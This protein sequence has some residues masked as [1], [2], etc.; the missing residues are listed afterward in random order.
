MGG[1]DYEEVR[2]QLRARGYL[3]GRLE[4]FVLHDPGRPLR[5]SAKAALLGAPVL[6]ALLAL[7]AVAA[8]RPLL[9]VRDALVLWLYFSVLAG[10][11]LWALDLAAAAAVSALARRRG[12]K[13]SDAL[14]AALLVGFPTLLY[15]VALWTTQRGGS[16]LGA[17]LAFLAAAAVVTFFTAWLAGLVSL[18]AIV[19]R[20]GEVPDRRRRPIALAALLAGTAALAMLVLR[21]GETDPSQG[22]PA[23]PLHPVPAGRLVVLGIDGLDADLARALSARD[24]LPALTAAEARGARWPLRRRPGAE[25]PEAWTTLLTGTPPD[26]HGVRAVG[27]E[28]LPGIATPLRPEAGP[29][30]LTAALRFLLPARTVP[31]SGAARGVRAVWE[32]VGLA[33]PSAAV[34]FWSTWP[35]ASGG[36]GGYVVSDRALP[37]L[38]HAQAEADRA[39]APEAL[40]PRLR[41]RFPAQR[42][43]LQ[44]EANTRFAALAPR[45]RE[46]AAE[47]LLIDGWSLDVLGWLL[48]DPGVAMAGVY[49]PGLDILR[50]RL[51]EGAARDDAARLLE[52][53][54]A[55]EGYAR[56][57]DARLAPFLAPQAGQALVVAD[58][59]RAE[60][61]SALGFV[62]AVGERV[63]LG[64]TGDALD[65]VNVAPMALAMAGFPRSAE[66]SGSL[67]ATCPLAG[68][69]TGTVATYGRRPRAAAAER[70]AS[71]PQVLERLKSLGYL[72]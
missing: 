66:L 14:R 12:A 33:R 11:G 72:R 63:A 56:W 61:G 39:V 13:P 50:H 16:D 22:S 28:R 10:A 25:P 55:L 7:A 30:P 54:A 3:E 8:N 37:A 69:P 45:T 4:R 53:Q 71:D 62:L 67:P 18:A 41:A 32:V 64:C 43:S 38:L 2:R 48:Q 58:A 52:M 24:A 51:L 23:S 17:D 70:S 31:T 40:W 21:A 60:Q 9:G 42:A 15:L 19:G 57:L 1:A 29:V 20:T 35:A 49:L 68:V 46:L 27:V 34:G 5:S 44:E 59:G 6:G 47:S 36:A 26:V 65:P